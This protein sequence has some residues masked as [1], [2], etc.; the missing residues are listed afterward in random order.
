MRI[1]IA[2]PGPQ[3]SVHDVYVGWSEA[4]RSLGAQVFPFNLN[5]RLTFYESAYLNIDGKYRKALSEEQSA[6]M[7]LL[8]LEASL[9]KLRP[10]VL[11]VVSGFF[12]RA[13]ILDQARRYGTK[14]VL[15]HT[16]SPYEDDRQLKLAEHGDL[17]LLNDPTNLE[18]YKALG[19][20]VYMPHAY[21]PSIHKPGPSVPRL[22]CD[23]AFVGTGYP[24]RVAFLE[25]MNLDGLDVVLGGSWQKLPEQ[26]PLRK[27]IGHDIDECMDNASAVPLYRSARCGLNLYRRESQRPELSQGWSVGPREIEQAACGLP[28][29][30]DPRPEGDELF[31]MLPT[32]TSPGD[33]SEKLR[34]WL[35]HDDEREAAAVRAMQ[36]VADR[37]FENNA[38]ELLRQLERTG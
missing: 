3:F 1:L 27:H 28:F 6:G 15:L 35:A 19:P 31:P 17:S 13:D 37:T 25:A 16:E 36:A 7:A 24:S 2:H 26:S 12:V 11:I 8:G 20:A 38:A 9:F 5:D 22:K 18:A 4:L 32:F 33:A 14:V 10:H 21:R 30:R 29:L 23:L 34:W